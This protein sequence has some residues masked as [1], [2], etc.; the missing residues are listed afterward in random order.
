MGKEGIE[1]ISAH[2]RQIYSLLH[3]SLMVYLPALYN[4]RCRNRTYIY[5]A[6]VHCLSHLTNYPKRQE[7]KPYNILCYARS[8][9][10]CLYVFS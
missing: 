5:A 3:L 1:P 8:C 7:T 10:L 9:C 4:G 2:S 6:T